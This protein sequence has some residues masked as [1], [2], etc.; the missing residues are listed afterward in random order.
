VRRPRGARAGGSSYCGGSG[1]TATAAGGRDSRSPPLPAL[2]PHRGCSRSAPAVAPV[3]DLPDGSLATLFPG[4][5]LPNHHYSGL[6]GMPPPFS[7]ASRGGGTVQRGCGRRPRYTDAFHSSIPGLL[8]SNPRIFPT[9]I[10]FIPCTPGA[11][12]IVETVSLDFDQSCLQA[13]ASI[14][15][16]AK[17]MT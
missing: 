5:K 3:P 14:I 8:R 12:I 9:C 7:S 13:F 2:L 4:T 10:S 15:L 16:C 17:S 11:C 1:G 6:P